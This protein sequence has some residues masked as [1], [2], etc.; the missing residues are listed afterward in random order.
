[1]AGSL[2]A[3]QICSDALAQLGQRPITDITDTTNPHAILCNS[4]YYIARD[5]LLSEFMW[6]FA[7]RRVALAVDVT[8]PDFGYTYRF[9]LPADCLRVIGVDSREYKYVI[10]YGYLL[11]NQE[12]LYLKYIARIEEP[13]RFDPLFAEALGARIARKLAMPILKKASAVQIA[14]G[15]YQEAI[16]RAKASD[17]IQDDEEAL[18]A[19]EQCSYLAAR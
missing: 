1:M 14:E 18:T 9:Q 13:G 7:I 12:T 17:A 2:S 11:S 8:A 6:S 5:S 19:E 3:E 16:A 10:E 4:V 15:I